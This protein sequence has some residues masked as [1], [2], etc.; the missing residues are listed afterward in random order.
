MFTQAHY[1]N[2]ITNTKG[3]IKE[4]VQEIVPTS[5]QFRDEE[6]KNTFG[7]SSHIFGLKITNIKDTQRTS[8][9]HK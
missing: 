4:T 6:I 9:C 8:N 2:K 5:T 7:A 1:C 3:K